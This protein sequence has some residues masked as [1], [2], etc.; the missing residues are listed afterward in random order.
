MSEPV[1][2][3]KLNKKEKKALA[4]RANKGKAKGK[5]PAE[6]AQEEIPL[7]EDLDTAEED[8]QPSTNKKRKRATEDEQST[9]EDMAT[10]DGGEGDQLP[11]KKKRQR[12][13]MNKPKISPGEDAEGK[14]KL[15]LF[16]GESLLPSYSF[17]CRL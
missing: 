12:G 8:R 15:V 16:I 7:Q 6:D 1:V 9:K 14:P 4:F 17:D 11:K 3:R 13:G 5:K 2:E 10:T